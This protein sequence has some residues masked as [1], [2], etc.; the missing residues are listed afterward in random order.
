[1]HPFLPNT[2]ED[3][4]KMLREMGVDSYRELVNVIPDELFAKKDIDIPDAL[5]ELEVKK[6]VQNLSEKNRE[7]KIFAGAGA[8]DHFV[9]AVIKSIVSRPEFY[10]A[11]TPYQ[12]EVSQGTLQA[13][14]EFQSMVS[15]LTG[16]E[17]TNASMYDGGSAL[18]EAILM[19]L[20]LRKGKNKVLISSGVN[21][22]YL[23]VINTYLAGVHPE[24]VSIPIEEESGMTGLTAISA[25][26]DDMTCCIV[27]QHPNY[28]GIL[29]DMTQVSSL[30]SFEN[31][32][33]LIQHYNPISL[34]ILK[35]PSDFGV[36]IAT[37][38]GQPLGIPVS[39]GGPYMGLFSTKQ[40]YIRQ[41]PGRL[42]GETVDTKGNKGYVMTLQTREQHIRREKAT[43]NICSN[44]NLCLLRV[45]VYLSLFGK[46]G[47]KEVAELSAY[48]AHWLYENLTSIKG[49]EPAFKGD[50][51]NEFAI[52]VE[53][54]T[55][56]FID[57]MKKA[58]ILAGV[59]ID[60]NTLLV[61]VT[62]KRTQDEL[63]SYVE[64]AG[65]VVKD[66]DSSH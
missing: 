32:P 51:F 40:K 5:S 45:L 4:Q 44:Q 63:D 37:A 18:A 31:A 53:I 25:N 59:P 21:P 48:N 11:Y 43:S 38:E 7:L 27:L 14:F 39:F 2:E 3:R 33:L 8:Y 22:L 64:K 34:G 10:T 55:A 29:E 36:D 17:V 61:A 60:K 57:R 46:K 19:A 52:H 35:P 9:P 50:F 12:A 54:G 62:E 58:G 1:M 20:R 16:M 24:L 65:I 13:I 28:Y 30:L 41:M 6:V 42:I 26:M 23:K 66:Y 49:I 47:L 56:V 15:D